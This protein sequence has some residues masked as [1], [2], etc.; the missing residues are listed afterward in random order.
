MFTVEAMPARQG[1]ALLV[2]WG[3]RTRPHRML[4]DAGTSGAF[5]DGI[6]ERLLALP[7]DAE[8]RRKIDLLVITHIDND[9][10]EGVI[11]VLLDPEIALTPAD[12]WFNGWKHLDPK[13]LGGKEGEWLGAL[14]VREGHE[15]PWNASF[16]EKAVVVDKDGLLPRVTIAGLELTIVSPGRPQLEALR[17]KWGKAVRDAGGTPGDFDAAIAALKEKGWLV[18]PTLGASGP[19]KSESNGSSIAFVATY[20]GK[21]V[22]FT[23]DAF[24]TVLETNLRRY[25]REEGFDDDVVPLELFKVSHHGSRGNIGVDLLARMRCSRFLISTDGTTHHH[26]DRPAIDLIIQNVPGAEIIFNYD[27]DQTRPFAD[28]QDQADRGFTATYDD[29]TVVTIS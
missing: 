4:I 5:D 20:K 2:E 26:P 19:D 16:D 3:T 13:R 22:L 28:A 7:T 1:D 9:H 15:H 18:D 24:A 17:K 10:I 6:R 14:L 8:G 29:P 27:S 25:A 23:G 11:R 12:V 21:R